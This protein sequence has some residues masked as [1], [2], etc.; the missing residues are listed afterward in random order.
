M[1]PFRKKATT[2]KFTSIHISNQII[3]S[4]VSAVWQ[5]DYD[6]ISLDQIIRKYLLQE[7]KEKLPFYERE[8]KDLEQSL[9]FAKGTVEIGSFQYQL[10]QLHNQLEQLQNN[11]T[12]YDQE[13]REI[14]ERYR[15]KKDPNHIELYLD[16]AKKYYPHEICR[17]NN[18]NSKICPDHG[19]E[20]VSFIRVD[21]EASD[22]KRYCPECGRVFIVCEDF[23][24]V[25][26]D[27][28]REHD[29]L[30]NFEKCIDLIEGRDPYTLS[31]D[32][33][34]KLD[35]YLLRQ[36]SKKQNIDEYL[37]EAK[38][39]LTKK[40]IIQILKDIG[41]SNLRLHAPKILYEYCGIE[42]PNLSKYRPEIREDGR[43][44]RD[45]FKA[46]ENKSRGSSLH[47]EWVL[48]KILQRRKFP[49]LDP[50]DFRH[51]MSAVTTREYYHLWEEI[52]RRNGWEFYLD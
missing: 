36:K 41:E 19:H 1:D 35:D 34:K 17:L 15:S 24:L 45:A 31:S 44:Y 51:E 32:L 20:L 42:P 27:K 48:Y 26:N 25:T 22:E 5:H 18:N 21:D 52:C 46:I 11:L 38:L 23:R 28:K 39:K 13:T 16:I 12:I 6:I 29:I 43:L 14:L 30:D 7:Q 9:Q 37:Q 3:P 4:T 8:K 50:E 49:D 40:M 47:S 33:R 2:K 10:E